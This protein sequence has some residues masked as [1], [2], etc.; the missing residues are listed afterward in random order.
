MSAILTELMKKTIL[1]LDLIDTGALYDSIQ[2]TTQLS[3]N[4]L[5]IIVESEDYIKFHVEDKDIVGVFLEQSGCYEE[6]EKILQPWIENGI[7]DIFEGR[8]SE[9]LSNLKIRVSFNS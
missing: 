2:V 1:D 6:F 7:R 8:G 3:Q 4:E 9:N 5:N